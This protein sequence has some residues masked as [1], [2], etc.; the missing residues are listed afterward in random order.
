MLVLF[1]WVEK[2]FFTLTS[3]CSN[4]YITLEQF[5]T[6]TFLKRKWKFDLLQDLLV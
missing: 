4:R 6:I 2:H 3:V 5:K 1:G